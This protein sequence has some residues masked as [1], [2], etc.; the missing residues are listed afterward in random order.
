MLLYYLICGLNWYEVCRFTQSVY[1]YHYW[2]IVTCFDLGGPVMK[3]N[4]IT[5]HFHSGI[6]IGCINPAG[7]RCSTFTCWH[8]KHLLDRLLYLFSYPANNI[9]F[10]LMSTSFGIQD[11]L[12]NCFYDTHPIL[13]SS[14]PFYLGWLF[15]SWKPA[16]YLGWFHNL[17]TF[18]VLQIPV[19]ATTKIHIQDLF[20][21]LFLF[22][23]EICIQLG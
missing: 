4:E 11:A 12:H 15:F 22:D 10:L 16:I 23:L 8:S 21:L 6:G 7:C 1:Y 17:P 19:L 5:S 13:E 18:L 20:L 3:S 9:P 14:N 2:V